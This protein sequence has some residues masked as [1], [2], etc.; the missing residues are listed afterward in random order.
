MATRLFDL[1]VQEV[2]AHWDITHALRELIA[3]ALDE[4]LLTGTRDI[5]VLRD[6]AGLVHIQDFGRGLRIEHFTLN[7]NPEKLAH[8]AGVIGKF[9]VGLKD[10]LA[11]L[12]RRGIDISFRSP[13]GC[14][15]VRRAAK[16]S[17]GIETLHVEYDDTPQDLAGTQI[18]L[19]GVSEAE[20]GNAKGYFLRY[21]RDEVLD[22]TPCGQVLRKRGKQARVYISGVLAN[23][24]PG[25]LFSY[26]ITAVPA[27]MRAKLN[28][29]R[30]H[31]GRGVYA[32]QV[33]AILSEAAAPAV[34]ERLAEQ[35]AQRGAGSTCEELTWAD[36][37]QR[38]LTLLHAQ[39]RVVL[40][41]EEELQER[42]GIIGDARDDGLHAVVIS[43]REKQHL[44]RQ[45]KTG[46][47]A[48]RTLEGYVTEYNESFQYQFVEPDDLTPD[49]Q[50]CF[51]LTDAVLALVGLAG[52]RRPR[53]R[54]SETL[55]TGSDDT[56]GLWEAET[57][58]LVVHRACLADS[59]TYAGVLLHEAAH[60]Q[61]APDVS[62]QFE[63]VLTDFLGRVA[64]RAIEARP[65]TPV[66]SA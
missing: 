18:T 27:A 35:A 62:R 13:H 34:T 7:E 25:F 8:P 61:G 60:M 33:R 53:V 50:R 19:T 22:E 57:R 9:G 39:S 59:A 63:N 37:A 40:V 42:P 48:V 64:L 21:V 24:E 66:E 32:E 49:E 4:Q 20:L 36:V 11:T 15:R 65:G 29:E 43:A 31:V 14:F 44:A 16:A 3:N 38:A 30:L 52:R 2:L 56:Q 47:P 10:A 5:R 1:N 41:T 46:G 58:T 26:N 51:A 17:F 54:V 55:R 23:T 45:A 28:R 6:A 12:H